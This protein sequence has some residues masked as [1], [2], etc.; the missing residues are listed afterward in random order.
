MFLKWASGLYVLFMTMLIAEAN[1]RTSTIAN[2]RIADVIY[3]NY[4]YEI[5]TYKILSKIFLKRLLK[6]LFV[7]KLHGDGSRGL[8]EAR[9]SD[10]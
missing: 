3:V 4:E 6:L 9:W 10:L 5:F 1:I 8:R 7:L 2:N